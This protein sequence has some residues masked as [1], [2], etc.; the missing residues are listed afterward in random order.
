MPKKYLTQEEAA[1]HLGVTVDELKAMREAGT[2][3][4]FADRGTWKF[5]FEDIEELTRSRQ[6]TSD[7]EIPLLTDSA[8]ED[9]EDEVGSQATVIRGG[10][11]GSVLDDDGPAGGPSDSDVRLILD[12]S[13]GAERG[14]SGLI[15][16]SDVPL[17]GDSTVRFV[18]GSGIDVDNELATFD[19]SDSD[20]RLAG[21]SDVVDTSGSDSDVRLVATPDESDDNSDSDVRLIGSDSDSDVRLAPSASGL[22]DSDSDVQ[23]VADADSG[24][25]LAGSD[26]DVKL[27][28]SDSGVVGGRS[29]SDVKLIGS[30]VGLAGSDSDV[31]LIGSDRDDRPGSDSDVALVAADGSG[32]FIG[33]D[34]ESSIFA[35]DDDEPEDSGRT[36]AAKS[37]L[38]SPDD[39]GINLE[40]G[41]GSGIIL[42]D[43]GSNPAYAPS[44]IGKASDYDDDLILGDDESEITLAD[45]PSS[46]ALDGDSIRL[47][48][49]S[50]NL[51]ATMPELAAFDDE[52]DDDQTGFDIPLVDDEDAQDTFQLD[53]VGDDSNVIEFEDEQADEHAA[54]VVRKGSEIDD[55]AEETFDLS[56]DEF[57]SEEFDDE[58]DEFDDEFDDDELEVS[59]DIDGEDDEL[60]D[61]DV[62]DEADD[63]EEDFVAGGTSPVQGGIAVSLE[64][65]WGALPFTMLLC[66][67][68][69][70]TVGGMMMYDLVRNMW[71]AGGPT[72]TGTGLLDWFAS[73]LFS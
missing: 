4:G 2:V 36:I 17:S 16:D 9:D 33:D 43:D 14:G 25:L 27:I 60:D 11:S 35:P 10:D 66:S 67:F 45:D 12:D 30:D 58:F 28:A 68:L 46:I 8:I 72:A 15:S 1:A 65:E 55:D 49:D 48:S 42:E 24:S 41:G 18:G 63:F 38:L 13:L 47:E 61:L 37:G 39:S 31:K 50:D 7:P 26:S 6:A 44:A 32:L 54:T 5:K 51:D 56:R 64:P 69:V 21:A 73:T 52:E 59:A 22:L 3:R 23:L 71:A 57:E 62:F 40:V 34:E 19:D 70:L 20:V 29:D 53:A